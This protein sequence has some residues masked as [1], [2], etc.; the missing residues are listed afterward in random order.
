MATQKRIRG[1]EDEP[2]FD[3][4]SSLSGEEHYGVELGEMPPQKRQKR[5][6]APPK[7]LRPEDVD[8]RE[9]YLKRIVA[10]VQRY[11]TI[12]PRTSH[13][14][15]DDLRQL[16]LEELQNVLLNAQ[17]DMALLRGTP[18]SQALI[19]AL[20]IVDP[21]VGP[22]SAVCDE[23]EEL[24]QDIE[25]EVTATLG[26]LGPRVNIVCRFIANLYRALA[27]TAADWEK[28]A[29]ERKRKRE[30]LTEEREQRT[31]SHR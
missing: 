6:A 11:R 26:F 7:P 21:Y 12:E 27:V 23:D 28:G 14:L 4:S 3:N 17:A 2:Q 5:D 30:E 19:A 9:E 15:M 18:S 8:Q 22:F 29:A 16:S 1:D 20:R 24:K 31:E 13:Q 10:I 25:T